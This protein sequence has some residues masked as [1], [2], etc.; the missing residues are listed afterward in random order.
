[1]ASTT[2]V[3]YSQNTPIVAPWLNDI[4]AAV[5]NAIG[6]GGPTPA[7]PKSSVDVLTNLGLLSAGGANN[8]EYQLAYSGAVLRTLMAKLLEIP[9][10]LD[11]GAVGDGVADDSSH[12]TA[13][14]ADLTS[15]RIPKSPSGNPYRISSNITI[16]CD[17]LFEGGQI[18]VDAG[19]TVTIQGTVQAPSRVLFKGAGIVNISDGIGNVVW[20]DG[21]TADAKWDF[22]RR[23]LSDTGHHVLMFPQVGPQ[24]SFAMNTAM[25]WAWNLANPLELVNSN[26]T[27]NGD[28]IITILTYG[29]FAASANIEAVWLVSKGT[30]KT[31]VVNFPL[32]LKVF[33]LNSGGFVGNRIASAVKINGGGHH[34][35]SE[36]SAWGCGNVVWLAPQDSNQ[37]ND[38]KIR[39]IYCAGLTDRAVKIEG[40]AGANNTVTDCQI[41]FINCDGF[42]A[43]AGVDTLVHIAGTVTGFKL[44]K[45]TLRGIASV[46]GYVDASLA[47]VLI[48]NTASYAPGFLVEIG[49][50]LNGSQPATAKC[51]VVRDASGGTGPKS[52][53]VCLYDGVQGAVSPQISLSYCT[54]AQITPG[55]GSHVTIVGDASN[56]IVMGCLPSQVTDGGIN[57]LINGHNYGGITATSVG[58]SPVSYTNTASYD[59]DYQVQGGTVSNVVLVR[60]GVTVTLFSGTSLNAGMFR[61]SPGDQIQYAFSAAP[62][63]NIIPR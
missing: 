42:M 27:G 38:L 39:A 28:S 60:Q 19:V 24:D 3:D 58:A 61:L 53:G 36:I 33:D 49:S 46:A 59:I 5:Y 6:T 37:V 40:T 41:D 48:E 32:E 18:T 55:D 10:I 11:L 20:Y 43:S 1:M 16:A 45:V 8:V 17:M 35:W 63:A 14:S 2:F 44:G 26:G 34:N 22:A 25:G 29:P 62:A 21:A 23:G 50:I 12:F 56:T 52:G 7:A 54:N 4:N 30:S 31:D 51:L 13:A 57:T 47:T 15:V 9:S